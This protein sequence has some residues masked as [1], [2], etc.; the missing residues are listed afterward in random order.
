MGM[1]YRI[2]V[3][4]D[5]IGKVDVHRRLSFFKNRRNHKSGTPK[6]LAID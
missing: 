4:P 2:V 6:K 3:V 5:V 1:A